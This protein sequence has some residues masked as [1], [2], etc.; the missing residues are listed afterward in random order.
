MTYCTRWIDYGHTNEPCPKCHVNNLKWTKFYSA[1]HEAYVRGLACPS[2]KCGYKAGA[3]KGTV[4][5]STPMERF[6]ARAR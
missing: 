3:T 2:K 5:E 6:N 4:K 1:K